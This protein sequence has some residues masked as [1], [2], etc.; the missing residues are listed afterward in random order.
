MKKVDFALFYLKRLNW[1]I[2]PVGEDK[3]PL[4][5]WQKYQNERMSKR[6]L[7]RLFNQFPKANLAV[8]TGRISN[9]I[10]VDIDPRHGGTCNLFENIKT[11]KSK[12]GG[13]G[14]HYFFKYKEGIKNKANIKPGIDIRGE[15]GYAILPP[16]LHQSGNR[17]KWIVAPDTEIEIAELPESIKQLLV[18]EKKPRRNKRSFKPEILKGV[19]K[20]SRNDSAAS[21]VGKFL[22]HFP[23]KDW[24]SVAWPALKGWNRQNSP[25]LPEEE[26]R[27]TFESIK[28]KQTS[29]TTTR[30]TN[31]IK[32]QLLNSVLDS[33]IELFHNQYKEAYASLT[34]DGR[35]V[36]KVN[37]KVFTH[38]LS[39]F[40]WQKYK[41]I[42]RSDIIKSIREALEGIAIHEGGLK[43]LS[44]R[45]A[46][47]QNAIWYDLGNK[48]A[49]KVDKNGW[50]VVKKPPILF[51]RY[52]HQEFQVLPSKGIKIHNLCKFINL[53]C[54]SDRLLFLVYVITSFIPGFSH[55]ILVLYGP[56]GSGKTIPLK[57]QKSL[58]DPSVLKTLSLVKS[59][60]EFTQLAS[61]HYFLN[62]DN[63]SY[64]SN[65]LSDLLAKACTGDGFSKR[66]LYTDDDDKIYYI[67]KVIALNGINLVANKPDL[68]D[69]TIIIK[70]YRIPRNH[71]KLEK[72]IL[73]EFE[74]IKPQ[75]LHS[76]FDVL[77]KALKIYPTINIKFLPRMADFARS[78]CA[79]TEALGYKSEE[80][81]KAYY[82][83]IGLQNDVAIE[84]SPVGTVILS[85]MEDCSKW[86]GTPSELLQKLTNRAE[87]MQINIKHRSWPKDA[88]WLSRRM[89]DIESNLLEEGI[90]IEKSRGKDRKIII[91]KVADN[92]VDDDNGDELQ[93]VTKDL[94]SL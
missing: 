42:S 53:S 82:S 45:I 2:I 89:G 8:I 28:K 17:Y 51:R 55:P 39:H 14:F 57:L 54:E 86:E 75:L 59:Q 77:S 48:G 73:D 78:G 44:V 50:R 67:Q 1:N 26:L 11:V 94:T 93:K 32:E 68:L 43:D 22:I 4:I 46:S 33:G 5:K 66:K 18:D 87:D 74:K 34:G 52:S 30:N 58:I 13:D 27:R 72:N 62:F 23:Q 79:V 24:E 37:S 3:K 65:D 60:K 9:L 81:L 49:V 88:S 83:N 90:R 61:H 56:Q 41:K 92:A 47:Y 6:E 15:G 91:V 80:F 64:I 7:K 85:L 71:R 35:E 19:K 38:W 25:S 31:L 29:S 16:S 12:T 40:L 36:M 76:I 63:I 84:A 70:L 21:I 20:G 10:I 69:R